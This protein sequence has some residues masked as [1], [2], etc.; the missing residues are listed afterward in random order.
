MVMQLVK[1]KSG[2][3]N[4]IITS[5]K[6]N[7]LWLAFSFLLLLFYFFMPDSN[8]YSGYFSVR[9]GL[10]L[11]LFFIVWIATRSYN[12]WV[13]I[14]SITLIFI[15]NSGL[16][17]YYLKQVRRLNF[18]AIEIN[19]QAKLIKENTVVLP[20]NFSTN[21]IHGHLSNYLGIDKPLVILENYEC[22]TGYFP[23]KWN[24]NF[25]NTTIG[26]NSKDDFCTDWKTNS[27][28]TMKYPVNF[29]FIL[30]KQSEINKNKCAQQ[31][32][33]KISKYY[34]LISKTENTLLFELME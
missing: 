13:L 11:F 8:G 19:N 15:A 5:V 9:M 26:N 33:E 34:H 21:W 10:L 29:I 14:I 12:K 31:S 4:F 16:N 20:M 30:G 22:G 1:L 25:P 3:T 23:L 28:S 2:F 32:I 7:D 17:Y 18:L 6:Q 27:L 24:D